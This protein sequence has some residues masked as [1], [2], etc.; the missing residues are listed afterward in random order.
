MK[1]L[2]RRLAALFLVGAL[3]APLAVLAADPTAEQRAFLTVRVNGQEQGTSLVVLRRDDAYVLAADLK[4]ANLV[5][6]AAAYRTV[7][8]QRYVSLR[9]VDPN[10]VFAVDPDALSIEIRFGTAAFHEQTLDGAG[11]STTMPISYARSG[12]FNYSI[13]KADRALLFAGDAVASVGHGALETFVQQV[14]PGRFSLSRTSWTRDDVQKH[15][16]LVV[17]RSDID[18]NDFSGTGAVLTLD[19]ITFRRDLNLNPNSIR[20]YNSGI[21]GVA[22]SASTVDLYVN[23]VLVRQDQIGA[24]AFRIANL[25]LRDGAND[26]TVVVRDAFGHS[27]TISRPLYIGA[28]MYR[29]GER[30][31]A[32]GF[33]RSS[34]DNAQGRRGLAAVARYA[35]GITD[36]LTVGART[37]V[38][39][40]VWNVG[41]SFAVGTRLGEFAGSLS[42]SVAHPD[43]FG[44]GTVIDAGFGSTPP[45]QT[46]P[47]PPATF[48]AARVG[49]GAY[50]ISYRSALRNVGFGAS[51]V[52]ETPWY[53][54]ATQSPL[55]DRALRSE[56]V[57]LSGGLG[58]GGTTLSLSWS[59]ELQRDS[60]PQ[61]N[62]TIA[63]SQALGRD[64][65]ATASFGHQSLG[66]RSG[67]S[68][69]LNVF[70][71]LRGRNQVALSSQTEQGRM[72]R[73]VE[74]THRADGAIGTSY[75][76]QFALTS[77]G[78]A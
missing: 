42:K 8:G 23:G 63:I 16:R 73:S 78:P 6:P 9:A 3:F 19:G 76:A 20:S 29:R 50:A 33:G 15:T 47:L 32:F 37:Q 13:M 38:T 49:G 35:F 44:A 17:G 68:F 74:L 59:R 58:H 4:D 71:A 26:T 62:Q 61:S 64:L 12:F 18:V 10:A 39:P 77:G 72:S 65:H 40:D 11:Q 56:R 48:N 54:T 14:A 51:F 30:E 60:G 70:A 45:G 31:Y 34:A 43:P 25:P 53:S 22:T 27:Q 7:E 2:P 66:G 1:Q 67:K 69:G 24:G 21:S 5:I 46:T 75:S 55:A 28:D 41:S 52:G 57:F 36:G